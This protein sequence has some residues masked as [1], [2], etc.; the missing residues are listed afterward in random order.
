MLRRSVSMFFIGCASGLPFLMTLTVLDVWMKSEG[1][2]NTVIGFVTF[3]NIP[4]VLKFL[5]AHYI[6]RYKCPFVPERLTHKK[7]WVLFADIIIASGLFLIGMLNPQKDFWVLMILSFFVVF[8]TSI[9]NIALYSFQVDNLK[10]LEY[11]STAS[12]V[13][14]GY[15]VGMLIASSGSLFISSY[16]GWQASY[17]FIGALVMVCTFFV[18]RL[19]EPMEIESKERAVVRNIA[20]NLISKKSSKYEFMNRIRLSFFECLVF[21]FKIF[22]KNKNWLLIIMIIVS[23]KAGDVFVHKMSKPLYIELGFSL[24]DIA[25]VVSCFGFM[26][27]AIGG[28]IG[29]L[30]VKRIGTKRGMLYCNILHAFANLMYVFLYIKGYNFTLFYTSVALENL[31]GGMMMTAFLS[32]IYKM[33]ANCYPATQYSL[34]WGLH[35]FAANLFRGMSGLTVDC[36]GWISFYIIGFFI[37]IPSIAM[38]VRLIHNVKVQKLSREKERK[39]A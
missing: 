33:S 28:F 30:I 35:A 10:K 5:W 23:F 12:C 22:Q 8:A 1:I 16:F 29:G 36:V 7:G 4:Y 13:T 26:A 31:S 34:L 19:K 2:S 32:F 3:V 14:L 37:T 15:R 18:M 20:N 25:I 24:E 11:G 6:D 39:V 9:Q 21:P 27:T 17:T 38:M